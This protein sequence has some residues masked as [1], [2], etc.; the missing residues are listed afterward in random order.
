MASKGHKPT[1]V[2]LSIGVDMEG[3]K[4]TISLLEGHGDVLRLSCHDAACMYGLPEQDGSQ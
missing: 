1:D 2:S 3:P 4:I